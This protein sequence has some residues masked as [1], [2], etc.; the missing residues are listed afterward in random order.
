MIK[1]VLAPE[2]V[3]NDFGQLGVVC[4]GKAFFLVDGYTKQYDQ[5]E[6]PTKIRHVYRREFGYEVTPVAVPENFNYNAPPMS[7]HDLPEYRKRPYTAGNYWEPL[8]SPHRNPPNFDLS[9]LDKGE[10]RDLMI[11]AAAELQRRYK[12]DRVES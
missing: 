1:G 10:L 11:E 2:W 5:Y 7:W 6:G 12:Q 4:L 3:V 8:P 9:A